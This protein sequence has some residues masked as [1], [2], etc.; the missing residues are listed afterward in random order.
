MVGLSHSVADFIWASAI[1]F[2]GLVALLAAFLFARQTVQAAALRHS[3]KLSD[4]L[5][6]CIEALLDGSADYEAGLLQLRQHRA[7]A[8]QVLLDQ[9]ALTDSHPNLER[10]AR[11]RELCSDLGLV[12]EWR[13]QLSREP[14][15]GLISRLTRRDL[16]FI[17]RLPSLSFVARAEAAERLGLIGDRRSWPLLARALNDPNLVVRSVAARA[18]GRIQAPASFPMLARKLQDVAMGG[19][20]NLSLRSLKMTLASFPLI[21]VADLG[22][23]LQHPHRRVRFLAADLAAAMMEQSRDHV[24]RWYL[25]HGP[26]LDPIADIVLTGLITDQNPEV[27]ARA[28]DVI[29]HLDDE[30]AIAALLILLGDSE[31]FVRLHATR[32]LAEC[33]FV[34]L[35][36]LGGVLTDPNWRVREAAAQ[37]LSVQGQRGVG[38]LLAHFRTTTDRY[39]R[40]QAAEQ[41][42]RLGLI[43]SLVAEFG[44][45]CANAERQFIDGMVRL[46]R[47]ASLRDALGNAPEYERAEAPGEP[48]RHGDLPGPDLLRPAAVTTRSPR[49]VARAGRPRSIP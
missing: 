1:V 18:L 12:A 30:R 39:S 4:R 17:E 24:K 40:E 21:Y 49:L 6:P 23:M 3:R 47:M 25:P 38:F 10:V 33:E 37:A 19:D 31:W 9:V 44:D 2:A 42:E 34:P 43:P 27:R 7:Y 15:S 48:H 5:S 8:R 45:T 22:A 46:G 35:Q 41:I 13:G 11:L 16:T 32:A 20:R 26:L 29:A 14:L 36:A 28:A